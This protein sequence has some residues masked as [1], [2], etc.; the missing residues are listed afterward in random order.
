MV[1]GI[2]AAL[3]RVSVGCGVGQAGHQPSARDFLPL[4]GPHLQS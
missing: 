4:Y 2:P 1:F 3:N